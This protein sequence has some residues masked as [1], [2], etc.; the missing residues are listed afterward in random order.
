M[1]NR[2]NDRLVSMVEVALNEQP[3]SVLGHVSPAEQQRLA[4]L[5]E[6]CQF[7]QHRFDTPSADA[8]NRAISTMIGG[9][10]VARW[11][12]PI[13]PKMA[14]QARSA[15]EQH[16]FSFEDEGVKL[17]LVYT[18]LPLGWEIVGKVT[19]TDSCISIDDQS[20]EV[21]ASGHFRSEVRDLD[22]PELVISRLDQRIEV[23]NGRQL[24]DNAD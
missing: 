22:H 6:I 12:K 9:Q 17:R 14:L 21:E 1:F 7:L 8:L 24:L 4:G 19:P 20:I 16:S 13:A 10:R 5:G 11:V 3:I 23:A 18:P 2:P 15:S